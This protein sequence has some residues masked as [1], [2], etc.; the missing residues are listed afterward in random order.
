[1]TKLF[2]ILIL[3]STALLARPEWHGSPY[4]LP[5]VIVLLVIGALLGFFIGSALGMMVVG[6]VYS[7]REDNQEALPGKT[8]I[9]AGGI[10]GAIILPAIAAYFIF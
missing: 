8:A 3:L 7:L 6:F 4:F 9:S 10:V 2:I 1:M 5:V